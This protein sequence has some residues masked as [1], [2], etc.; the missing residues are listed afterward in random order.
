[1]AARSIWKGELKI[2]STAIP[3]KLY[4]AVEDRKVR[5]HVLDDRHLTRVKQPT[6]DPDSG[7]E[8]STEEIQKGY[9]LEPR[10]FVI[11]RLRQSIIT[12]NVTDR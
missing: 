4:S 1:M 11:L 9:Q 2:G 6:V 5:F 7:D 10:K 8:V 12:S 3:V